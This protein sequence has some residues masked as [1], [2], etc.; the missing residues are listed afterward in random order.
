MATKEDFIFEITLRMAKV[1][2][3]EG[4]P[5]SDAEKRALG[6]EA[7]QIKEKNKNDELAY[8]YK[9]FKQSPFPFAKMVI[10]GED[11]NAKARMQKILATRSSERALAFVEASQTPLIYHFEDPKF[12]K[13]FGHWM[14]PKFKI[15]ENNLFKCGYYEDFI[16]IIKENGT[17]RENLLLAKC[18]GVDFVDIGKTIYDKAVESG[19]GKE[20]LKADLRD[21]FNRRYGAEFEL[22]NGVYGENHK[23]VE[24]RLMRAKEELEKELEQKE[25]TLT[26]NEKK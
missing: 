16:K 2:L 5:L 21:V 11:Q 13:K 18:I 26:K 9:K 6:K 14:A 8:W 12:F 22:V 7:A 10:L 15:G 24:R 20:E 25:E 4:K 1:H 3:T 23:D 17:Y 19:I